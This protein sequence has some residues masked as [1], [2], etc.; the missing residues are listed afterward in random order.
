MRESAGLKL[1]D[2]WSQKVMDKHYSSLT[3]SEK[4]QF[5]EYVLVD[6]IG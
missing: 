1:L 5:L 4:K 2:N 6:D 3:P